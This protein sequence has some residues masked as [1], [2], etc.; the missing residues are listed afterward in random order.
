MTLTLTSNDLE[1]HIII[2]VLSTLT[3]IAIWFVAA[4]CLM[5]DIRKYIYTDGQTFLPGDDLKMGKLQH[6]Q[7]YTMHHYVLV[8][9]YECSIQ[10]ITSPPPKS[11]GKRQTHGI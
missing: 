9:L 6:I 4:L 2:N 7:T 11:R 10:I 5:V 3:N 1:S 8:M